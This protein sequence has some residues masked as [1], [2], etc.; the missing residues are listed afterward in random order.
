[1]KHSKEF[2]M[3]T[4]F[5]PFSNPSWRWRDTLSAL[6]MSFAVFT[7]QHVLADPPPL[8]SGGSNYNCA[9]Q[10]AEGNVL[11]WGDG[12]TVVGILGGPQRTPTA[13]PGLSRIVALGSGFSQHCVLDA[14]GRVQCWGDNFYGAVGHPDTSLR[15]FTTPHTVTGVP[16][17][18]IEVYSAPYGDHSC[19][20]STAF[21]AH[22]WG[23]N[24]RGQ[25]GSGVSAGFSTTPVAIAGLGAVAALAL[26]A[27]HTCAVTLAGAVRCWGRNREGQ[28][29]NAGT[30]NSPAVVDVQGLAGSVRAVAAGY[31][32]S[33]AVLADGRVKCW[34][35]NEY[36]ELGGGAATGSG[37]FSSVPVDVAGITDAVDV[38]A[39]RYFSCALRASGGVRCWGDNTNSALGNGSASIR[40]ATPTDVLGLSAPAIALTG[41]AYNPCAVLVT[42]AVQ[43]WGY[44]FGTYTQQATTVTGLSVDTTVPLAEFR[45]ASLDYYFRT[46]RYQEKILL[47]TA[48]AF[49][50]TAEAGI[51]VYASALQTGSRGIERYYFS[52]VARGGSRGSHF[53]TL[54]DAERSTLQSLNPGNADV[55][56]L[57]QSE[58]I[59]S[60]AFLPVT[61]GVGGTCAAGQSPVYR[62]FRGNARFPDDPNHRFT[63]SLATYNN[64]VAA[65]WD[66]EGV[67]FCVVTR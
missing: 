12:A 36:G 6:A 35:S 58:G 27:E 23:R 52:Q 5:E 67:K 66:G 21:T 2:I 55:P 28:L 29:G 15:S 22:C 11:C 49:Q 61:E 38:V 33:C 42:G 4:R 7:S 8:I 25:L 56:R 48:P 51:P 60:Y 34:G 24:Q 64:A 47:G 37:A 17:A 54:V 46:S 43:C 40:F 14:T 18:A 63:T 9:L 65:G 26:G 1:M 57:P 19:A 16:G 31:F 44:K 45:H 62:L 32:H 30:T 59:D 41:G 50:V 39:G 3:V 13:V 10:R 53:Y 20:I